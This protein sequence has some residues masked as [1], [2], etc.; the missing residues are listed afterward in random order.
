MEPLLDEQE[1]KKWL[2]DVNVV[3]SVKFVAKLP[4]P[5][6]LEEFEPVYSRMKELGAAQLREEIEAT[7]PKVGLSNLGSDRTSRAF[8]A[9]ASAAFGLLLRA[10][11]ATSECRR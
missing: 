6:G 1:F 10:E 8:I 3:E 9:L 11:P 7:N 5:A 2:A 4:N